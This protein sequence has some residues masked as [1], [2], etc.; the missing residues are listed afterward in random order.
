MM[1]EASG[2]DATSALEHVKLLLNVDVVLVALLPRFPTQSH[3]M[4]IPKRP[5]GVIFPLTNAPNPPTPGTNAI[6]VTPP[7]EPTVTV[8]VAFDVP[9]GPVAVSV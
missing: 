8:V 4:G 7:A 9:P 2:Q 1:I 3:V 6:P 5:A